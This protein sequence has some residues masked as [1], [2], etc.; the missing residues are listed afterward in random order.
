MTPKKIG[1]SIPTKSLHSSAARIADMYEISA[2][3]GAD[4]VPNSGF[5]G[6]REIVIRNM[7]K[8]YEEGT[9][10]MNELDEEICQL[11]SALGTN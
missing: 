6:E 11:R 7:K 1:E 8:V 5:P 2:G 9:R 4:N 10:M 3:V